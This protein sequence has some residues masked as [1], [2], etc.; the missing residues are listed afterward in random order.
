MASSPTTSLLSLPIP[1]QSFFSILYPGLVK[2]VSNAMAQMP[3]VDARADI[4]NFVR[5]VAHPPCFARS[6]IIDSQT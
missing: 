1:Q 3:N 6:F 5:V 2:N 4:M